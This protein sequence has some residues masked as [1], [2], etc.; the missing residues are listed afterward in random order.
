MPTQPSQ[1]F[2]TAP[3]ASSATAF[4]G[5][6][7]RSGSQER[8][9]LVDL[10][11][12]HGIVRDLFRAPARRLA[13]AVGSAALLG[14][15]NLHAQTLV[16]LQADYSTVAQGV[17]GIEYGGYTTANS[18][19]GTFT[20]APWT[21]TGS[22][23]YGGESLGTPAISQNYNHPAVNSL[24][25][26]VRRYTVGSGT[27]LDYTGTVQITGM[28]YDNA[29]GET[30]GFVTVDGVNYFNMAVPNTG[31][32]T[33]FVTFDFT[34][35]VAPGS[36]IDFGVNAGDNAFSD[37]TGVTATVTAVP[38]P[39]TIGMALAGAVALGW[40]RRRKG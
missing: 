24:T 22:E 25:P 4:P 26:A 2:Q 11:S 14:A 15:A 31:N 32:S 12:I 5:G 35:S 13:L 1:R 10:R 34:V 38:E 29:P 33:G 27:E 16:D 28:F 3:H 19:T 37:S 21:S 36:T 23:W 20:T 40:Y 9:S 6:P 8:P 30:S 7:A 17:N 18:I 39:G